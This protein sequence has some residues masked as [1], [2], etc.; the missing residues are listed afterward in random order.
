MA[1]RSVIGQLMGCYWLLKLAPFCSGLHPYP[2]V[3]VAAVV[4]DAS[5]IAAGDCGDGDS[6]GADGSV[7]L[8]Q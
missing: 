4:D 5:V 1:E 3:T 7:N 6:R 2:I 8:S